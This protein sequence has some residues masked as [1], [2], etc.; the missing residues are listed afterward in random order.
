MPA[1]LHP[2]HAQ[3]EPL[4]GTVAGA[5][6]VVGEDLSLPPRQGVAEGDDLGTS[7]LRQ[8]AMASSNNTAA[9][10]V[11]SGRYTSLTDS[12]LLLASNAPSTSSARS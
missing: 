4:G 11:S 12:C 1:A 10:G 2:L 5:G 6:V 8:A 7:S 3:V 9:S